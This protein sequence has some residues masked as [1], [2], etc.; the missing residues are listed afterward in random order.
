MHDKLLFLVIIIAAPPTPTSRSHLILQHLQGFTQQLYLH[1]RPALLPGNELFTVCQHKEMWQ[2]PTA[3]QPVCSKLTRGQ[4]QARQDAERFTRQEALNT[5][6]DLNAWENVKQQGLKGSG[7]SLGL[8]VNPHVLICTFDFVLAEI[9]QGWNRNLPPNLDC[10]TGAMMV[11]SLAAVID[12]WELLPCTFRLT[13]VCLCTK[14]QL[15]LH[16]CPGVL[17]DGAGKNT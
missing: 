2:E 14:Q 5:N 7:G 10:Q 11:W 3:D 16:N 13:V 6:I 8:Q 12:Y 4:T 17:G 15:R 9:S 1:S